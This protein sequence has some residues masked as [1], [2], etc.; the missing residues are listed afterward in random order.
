MSNF[1]QSGGLD[2]RVIR[3]RRRE[4]WLVLAAPL[5][6]LLLAGCTEGGTT[7]DRMGRFLVSPGK[8]N[9]WPCPQMGDRGDDLAIRQN[10]LE[11]LIAKAG[12]GAGG[13][14]ASAIAYRP[15]YLQVRADLTELR[16][17]AAG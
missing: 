2:G 3:A 4:H 8:Y 15:E 10:E 13:S 6:A 1:E 12:P 16:N 7:E 17:A 11:A 9:L 14:F 5:A